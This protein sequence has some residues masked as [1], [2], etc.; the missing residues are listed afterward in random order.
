MILYHGSTLEIPNLQIIKTDI[1][2]DFGFAF[3]TTEIK[4]QAERWAIRR[5]KLQ[6]RIKKSQVSAVVSVYEWNPSDDLNEK[7][8]TDASM[9]WLEMVVKCRSDL[10]YIHGY[11]VVRGKIA[12]DNVGETVSYVIQGIMRKE[13]AIERLK[14][15]KINSQTAFCTEK[16]LKDLQYI[17]SYE[18]E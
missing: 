8:F 7:I 12:N 4:E 15:E 3:Y 2:R 14:F 18:V 6:S 17:Q 11:D 16:S 1:G 5:A 9:D 13:D 10:N